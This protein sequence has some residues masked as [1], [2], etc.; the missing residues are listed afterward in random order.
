MRRAEWG[1]RRVP[2]LH[3]GGERADFPFLRRRVAVVP[4]GLPLAAND[5]PSHVVPIWAE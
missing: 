4:A 2:R 5:R 1:R 3:A